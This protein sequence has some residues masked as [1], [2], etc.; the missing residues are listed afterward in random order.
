M[1]VSTHS[2]P[3]AAGSIA[4][5][6]AITSTGF[7]SQPPEGGWDDCECIQRPRRGFNSQPPEGGWMA[8]RCWRNAVLTFQLT[9][10]RRRLAGWR[11]SRHWACRVSTH[12]RPKAAGQFD[13]MEFEQD[14]VS[15]HSRPKAAGNRRAAD[16]LSW[17]GF[18]SQPPEGGWE[19]AV[20]K[21]NMRHIV[22]TH[23][24]PKAA[25]GM[26]WML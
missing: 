14:A 21:Q 4:K 9:A 18:N 10:A 13:G 2:R 16:C 8:K 5:L 26:L 12:S 3:K 24:R 20:G 22:S 17:H 23:S 19:Q 25:G 1:R 6:V 11:G 15:T 7:N